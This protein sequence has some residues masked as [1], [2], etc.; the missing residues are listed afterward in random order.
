MATCSG[1]HSTGTQ[2][3]KLCSRARIIIISSWSGL[4]VPPASLSARAPVED[5][6]QFW[7]SPKGR[8]EAQASCCLPE[9]LPQ[10][11]AKRYSK[12]FSDTDDTLHSRIGYTTFPN[13]TSLQQ[14]QPR[15]TNPFAVGLRNFI[16]A[17]KFPSEKT[18]LFSATVREAI[19]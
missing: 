9:Y 8:T 3:S 6:R 13:R 4:R 15:R 2:R 7:N 14:R 16:V 19:A 18:I 1:L 5:H 17:C 10:G 11:A 12:I